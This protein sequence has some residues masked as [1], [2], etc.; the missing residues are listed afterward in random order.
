MI[1]AAL[2]LGGVLAFIAPGIAAGGLP[3]VPNATRLAGLTFCD[4]AL[5]QALSYP[6]HDPVLT[7]RGFVTEPAVML[8][9]FLLAGLIA[10]GF[11]FLFCFVGLYA[12]SQGLP[13]I[14][15]SPSPP[16]WTCPWW[17][18]PSC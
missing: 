1:L 10:G 4:L 17:S 15:C 6:F 9:G 3:Q 14:P 7:D 16:G 2:L 18:T 13:A 11:I 8:K 5:V 12:L